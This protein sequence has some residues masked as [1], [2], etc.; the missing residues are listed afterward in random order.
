MA[1]TLKGMGLKE[2]KKYL[3][4]VLDH[5]RCVPFYRFTGGVGRNSQ[6]KEFKGTTQGRWPKKACEIMLDLLRNAE[7]NAEVRYDFVVMHVA[8]T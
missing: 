4:Q 2:A 6:A 1:F 3:N 7:S 5:K 8:A